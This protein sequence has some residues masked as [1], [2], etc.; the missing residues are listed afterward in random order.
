[1]PITRGRMVLK[2][3]VTHRSDGTTNFH[4]HGKATKN[5]GGSWFAVAHNTTS[6][7]NR[8]PVKQL[9]REGV[10]GSDGYERDPPAAFGW[11]KPGTSSKSSARKA[12][13]AHIAKIPFVLACHIARAWY[14]ERMEVSA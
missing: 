13:S 5:D 11:K 1:M 4:G 3:G 10:K 9:T 2:A 7:K 14:P 6:G 8:N 12:A